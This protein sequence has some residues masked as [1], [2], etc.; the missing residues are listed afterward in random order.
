MNTQEVKE[1]H[2]EDVENAIDA[3]L[4]LEKYYHQMP[5]D[6]SK[7]LSKLNSLKSIAEE[8]IEEGDSIYNT[9]DGTV[10]KVKQVLVKNLYLTDRKDLIGK[11]F[12]FKLHY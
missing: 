8:E 6:L 1:K 7:A 12:C 10:D 9:I 11:K 5:N 3:I 2:I 4:N